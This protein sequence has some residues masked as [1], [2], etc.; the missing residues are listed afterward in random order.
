MESGVKQT[1]IRGHFG[2]FRAEVGGE[3]EDKEHGAKRQ[4]ED[5]RPSW[6]QRAIRL[7]VKGHSSWD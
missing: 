4:R 6:D 2:G 1:R 3:G 5:M 7:K